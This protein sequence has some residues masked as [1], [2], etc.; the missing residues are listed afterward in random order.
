MMLHDIVW[1]EERA[2]DQNLCN[3]V[4]NKAQLSLHGSVQE[5]DFPCGDIKYET[6]VMHIKLELCKAHTIAYENGYP[7]KVCMMNKQDRDLHCSKCGCYQA[8][9]VK[10]IHHFQQVT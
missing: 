6:N 2:D 9:E 10:R 3:V 4:I 8:L 5:G 7:I 1:I